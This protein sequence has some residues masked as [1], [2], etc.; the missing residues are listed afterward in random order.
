MS[1]KKYKKYQEEFKKRNAKIPWNIYKKIIEN[2]YGA[3][4]QKRSHS[5]GS[6]RSYTIDDQ[7]I[8]VIHEPHKKDGNVGKWDHQNVYD[9]LKLHGLIKDEKDNE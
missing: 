9:Q 1:K 8:F 5:G 7:I 6:K 4:E 2:D 3:V